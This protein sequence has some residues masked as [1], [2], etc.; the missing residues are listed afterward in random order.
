M[1]SD[2]RVLPESE[3]RL[4]DT[5]AIIG[6]VTE[7][8]FEGA[9]ASLGEFR[10]YFSYDDYIALRESLQLGLSTGGLVAAPVYMSLSTLALWRKFASR[11]EGG[12]R[13]IAH[14]LWIGALADLTIDG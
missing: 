10:D 8:D 9:T 7:V 1:P 5:V 11:H 6:I 13:P 4:Q 3:N 14:D 12:G 2:N